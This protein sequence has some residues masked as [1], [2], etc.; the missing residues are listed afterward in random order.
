M[1]L[2]SSLDFGTTADT[3]T[4]PPFRSSVSQEKDDCQHSQRCVPGINSLECLA[5]AR[6][7]SQLGNYVEEVSL[8]P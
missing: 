7:D 4:G 2:K 3:I 6:P 5:A 1:S 8:L